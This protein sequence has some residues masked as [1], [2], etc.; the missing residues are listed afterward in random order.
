MG[1]FDNK[2]LDDYLKMSA[3][4]EAKTDQIVKE[5]NRATNL[6]AVNHQLTN[7]REEINRLNNEIAQRDEFIKQQAKQIETLKK[8]IAAKEAV[9]IELMTL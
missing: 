7:N 1:F 3:D 5:I 2:L 8:E 9:I 6:M 4:S